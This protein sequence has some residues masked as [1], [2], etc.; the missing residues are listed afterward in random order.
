M[1]STRRSSE[2]E[3]N[4]SRGSGEEECSVNIAEVITGS[5]EVRMVEEGEDESGG[6]VALPGVVELGKKE[7]LVLDAPEVVKKE[8]VMAVHLEVEDGGS[9]AGATG[10]KGLGSVEAGYEGNLA[11]VEGVSEG[12]VS[13]GNPGEV[14]GGSGL[15]GALDGEGAVCA[16]GESGEM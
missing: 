9:K 5:E 16:T 13:L 3:R 6:D 14:R 4:I 2:L 11:D 1:S 10:D 8:G 12:K 7:S 15:R